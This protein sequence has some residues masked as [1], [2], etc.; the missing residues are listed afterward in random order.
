MLHLLPASSA[1]FCSWWGTPGTETNVSASDLAIRCLNK[2]SCYTL[3]IASSS[4]CCRDNVTILLCYVIDA[5]R[6]TFSLCGHYLLTDSH[7]NCC[8]TATGFS[9]VNANCILYG[10]LHMPLLLRNLSHCCL[11]C[12][13]PAPCAGATGLDCAITGVQHCVNLM[14][15]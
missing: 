5:F 7:C 11:I 8:M 13:I 10:A 1:F 6:N 9:S 2:Q 15:T 12:C 14:L 4:R 3:G